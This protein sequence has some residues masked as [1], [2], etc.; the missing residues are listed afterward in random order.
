MLEKYQLEKVAFLKKAFALRGE[1]NV[2]LFV[3]DEQDLKILP[4]LYIT[5]GTT[6]IIPAFIKEIKNN[7]EQYIISFHNINNRTQAEKY[8]GCFL[9]CPSKMLTC[10]SAKYHNWPLLKVQMVDSKKGKIGLISQ[11]ISTPA[12]DILLT[13]NEKGEEFFIPYNEQFI[14]S[15]SPRD[16]VV[17]VQLPEELLQDMN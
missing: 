17:K 15:Y 1:F 8:R 10:L 3:A 13:V 16:R 11:V 14:L 6:F 5:D 7:A 9:V 12:H 2:Q 4:V